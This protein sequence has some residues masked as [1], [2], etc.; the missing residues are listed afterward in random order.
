MTAHNFDVDITTP[1]T[2]QQVKI[3]KDSISVNNQQI[4][5]ADV[6]AV[7]Y[8]VSLLGGAKNPNGK[9]YI[10]DILGDNGKTLNIRFK[11]DKVG[12]LLEEDH[13]YYYI[14]SGLWQYVKKQLINH[15]IEELNNKKEITIADTHIN[16]QGFVMKYNSGF[17]FWKKQKTELVPWNNLKYYLSKGVLHVESISESKKHATFSLHNDWNAVVLN[18]MMHYLWQDQRKEKLA[19]GQAI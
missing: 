4:N 18:T 16:N 15:F 9:E 17:L 5:C 6:K 11:S 14:M 10:I 7:R 3:N 1:S 8:G 19:K 12:D 2:K 13:T